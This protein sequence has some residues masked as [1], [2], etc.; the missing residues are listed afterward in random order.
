MVPEKKKDPREGEG[1]LDDSIDNRKRGGKTMF[2]QLRN[3]RQGGTPSDAGT[4]QAVGIGK[5][6]PHKGHQRAPFVREKKNWTQE[7]RQGGGMWK[8]RENGDAEVGTRYLTSRGYCE[9]NTQNFW[10]K[11][12]R[13]K[14]TVE[15]NKTI[16]SR[17]SLWERAVV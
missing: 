4:Y 8:E 17:R 6:R 15:G 9:R 11:S 1:L 2:G 14:E 3:L 16:I 7:T 12:R 13:V 10:G 5:R